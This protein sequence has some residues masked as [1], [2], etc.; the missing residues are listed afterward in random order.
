MKVP[1][2]YVQELLYLCS[3]IQHDQRKWIEAGEKEIRK[4]RRAYRFMPWNRNRQN[5]VLSA[6]LRFI[7]ENLNFRTE[8]MQK[9]QSSVGGG[10]GESLTLSEILEKGGDL[11]NDR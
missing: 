7:N 3:A 10:K 5:E 11:F 8:L 2:L 4:H 9:L 1:G 6:R